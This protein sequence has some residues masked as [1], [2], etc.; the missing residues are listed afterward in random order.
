[1]KAGMLLKVRELYRAGDRAGLKAFA[2]ES[3]PALINKY[4]ELALRHRVQWEL[5]FKRS[6]WEVLA[7]RYG[8]ALSRLADARLQLS[9]YLDGEIEQIEELEAEPEALYRWQHYRSLTA[10]TLIV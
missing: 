7:L 4:D 2:L 3:I 8:A 1:M 9:R 6:G 10:P 5:A